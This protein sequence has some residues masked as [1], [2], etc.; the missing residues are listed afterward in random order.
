[1][2][3]RSHSESLPFLYVTR[4]ILNLGGSA[5]YT[6]NIIIASVSDLNPNESSEFVCNAYPIIFY[7]INFYL[8][9]PYTFYFI[10]DNNLYSTRRY[11]EKKCIPMI[12]LWC[13]AFSNHG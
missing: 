12:A 11:I 3:S 6:I 10:D 1:M 5:K 13:P 9:I 4:N 7:Y 2:V 8:I